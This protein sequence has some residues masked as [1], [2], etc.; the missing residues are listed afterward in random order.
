VT[1][2]VTHRA[3]RR[4]D[5]RLAETDGVEAVGI[6]PG[7]VRAG[8]AAVEIGDGGDH[9]G[10]GLGLG[11][12]VR[13]VVAARV[14][15]QRTGSVQSR[16]AAPAEI[17][18]GERAVDRPRHGKQPPR[19]FR[20]T[21]RGRLNGA[22]TFAR[23]RLGMRQ[24]EEGA[25]LPRDV[26]EIH[27]AAGLAD[28]VEQI[29]VLAGGGVGPLAGRALAALRA[30]EAHEHRAAGRV[31]YVA[32]HPVAALAVAVGQV[33]ATHRLGIARETVR[34]FG[35]VEPGHHSAS[36]SPTRSIG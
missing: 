9:G 5:R 23:L 36:R 8:E 19:G 22:T 7:P 31:A 21:R 29:A 4:V 17:R 24:A 27:E 1:E 3:A 10:P 26:R 35:S 15:A 16:N 32:H 28:D 34:Q 6:E 11:M 30:D 33:V 2:K 12:L 20:R 25:C 14:E 13:P 18:L